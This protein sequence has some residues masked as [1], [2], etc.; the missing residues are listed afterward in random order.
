[1][2]GRVSRKKYMKIPNAFLVK[3]RGE[4]FKNILLFVFNVLQIPQSEGKFAE[5]FSFLC[6]KN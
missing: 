5:H 4:T 3:D 6:S 2:C 1:M